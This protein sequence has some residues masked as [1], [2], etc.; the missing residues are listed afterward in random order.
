LSEQ[1]DYGEGE[2]VSGPL[3]SRV[4]LTYRPTEERYEWLRTRAFEQRRSIQSLVDEA[5]DRLRAAEPEGAAE[6]EG[7]DG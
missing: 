7:S 3:V 2:L 6:Q 1:T 5:V 4:A